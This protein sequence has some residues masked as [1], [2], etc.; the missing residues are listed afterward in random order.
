MTIDD[1]VLMAY[2]D[3]ELPMVQRSAIEA[4]LAQSADL[5]ER[6]AALRASM[7]PF[8]AAFD[9][10]KL[11]PVPHELTTR[12]NDLVRVS[13]ATNSAAASAF[14]RPA[15]R[16]WTRYAL[17]FAAG[18]MCLGVALQM[19]PA[20]LGVHREPTLVQAIAEYHAFYARETVVGI[21]PDPASDKATLAGAKS[22][23]G[24]PV[25]IPDLRSAGLEFKRVQRLRFHDK[26]LIQIVYLPERGRPVALCITQHTGADQSPQSE[27]VGNVA[28]VSWRRDQLASVL[29]AAD[30]QLDLSKLGEQ[31]A[32]GQMPD[33]YVN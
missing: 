24:L 10:Q 12:I 32:K 27:L 21:I 26:A 25:R 3:G 8:S 11:P 9:R 28:A 18:V 17:A 16:I 6:L 2:A 13:T 19:W 5:T 20:L 31:I 23:D 4:A 30:A 22:M 33:L 14:S 1:S 29:V 15:R 7:L